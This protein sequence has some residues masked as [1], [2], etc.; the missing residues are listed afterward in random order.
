VNEGVIKFALDHEASPLGPTERVAVEELAAWRQ[1]L[2]RLKLLGQDPSRYEGAGFGNVSLRLGE[3]FLPPGRRSFL[4]T[5]TQ[6][7]G[8][9]A[10]GLEDFALVEVCDYRRNA[11]RSRGSVRPSSE[12]MTHGAI[13]DLDARIRA[14]FHVHSP[15]IWRRSAALGLPTTDPSAAYGTPEMAHEVCRQYRLGD[16]RPKSLLV[17][18]GHEDGVMVFGGSPDQAGSVL[19]T[20]MARC[21]RRSGSA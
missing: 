4:I 9:A 11:V 2:R 16:M 17:M 21:L 12:A 13:Y 8:Q 6:T 7:A 14:V 20:W 19:V 10:V 15:D 18:G 5:G 3:G 1:I